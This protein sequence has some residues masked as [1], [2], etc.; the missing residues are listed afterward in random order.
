M[1]ETIARIETEAVGDWLASPAAE[2]LLGAALALI[3]ERTAN[4]ARYDATTIIAAM[5]ETAG[6][7]AAHSAP[8]EA[9]A[10]GNDDAL[11]PVAHLSDEL[12]VG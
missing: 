6:Y 12:P 10:A 11:D 4:G 9:S 2:H 5:R 8:A 3:V 1:A 7:A